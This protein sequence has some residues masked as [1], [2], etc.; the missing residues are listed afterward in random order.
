MVAIHGASGGE[1]VSAEIVGNRAGGGA[2]PRSRT[3]QESTWSL[4]DL[5][6]CRTCSVQGKVGFLNLQGRSADE[7]YPAWGRNRN[8]WGIELAVPIQCRGVGPWVG[9]CLCLK[10]V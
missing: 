2:F 10:K 5:S 1:S 6:R 3:E 9:W 4:G 7:P 8:D